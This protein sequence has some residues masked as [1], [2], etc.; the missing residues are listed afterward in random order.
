[1]ARSGICR[2]QETL[3]RLMSVDKIRPK[4]VQC[5]MGN[6]RSKMTH[7]CKQQD[8]FVYLGVRGVN[9]IKISLIKK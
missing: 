1:M 9:R 8:A 4:F 7:V 6:I 5:P 3:I 2:A